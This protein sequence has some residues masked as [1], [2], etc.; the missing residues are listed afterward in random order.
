MVPT[1]FFYQLLL[2]AL[3][4]VFLLLYWLEPNNPAV[5]ARWSSTRCLPDF[6]A[7][8]SLHLLPVASTNPLCRLL[9]GGRTSQ[10]V[11]SHATTTERLD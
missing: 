8:A 1:L 3:L 6:S 9:A 5:R 11:C 10:N 2:V 4:W 7:H